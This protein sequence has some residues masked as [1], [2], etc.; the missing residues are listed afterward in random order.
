MLFAKIAHFLFFAAYL[1][2]V[3]LTLMGYREPG[4]LSA[5]TSLYLVGR[6][7]TKTLPKVYKLVDNGVAD[8]KVQSSLGP[9]L[10]GEWPA[11]ELEGNPFQFLINPF[12]FLG[13]G[14]RTD[15]SPYAMAWLDGVTPSSSW[16]A[17]APVHAYN[18]G[19][20]AG[21]PT[22]APLPQATPSRPPSS[23]VP[24]ELDPVED[25]SPAPSVPAAST[26]DAWVL[27]DPSPTHSTSVVPAHTVG[28]SMSV[29]ESVAPLSPLS[30]AEPDCP[31][32]AA[33]PTVAATVQPPA[34]QAI[35]GPLE[36]TERVDSD[37]VAWFD[38][39]RAFKHG[40]ALCLVVLSIAVQVLVTA[41]LHRHYAQRCIQG[42]RADDDPGAATYKAF[43]VPEASSDQEI[44]ELR[45]QLEGLGA[46]QHMLDDLKLS[47]EELRSHIQTAS[48]ARKAKAPVKVSKDLVRRAKRLAQLPL[49]ESEADQSLEVPPSVAS[50]SQLP[51]RSIIRTPLVSNASVSVID[52]ARLAARIL[53]ISEDI[54]HGEERMD[55]AIEE[56]V[57]VAAELPQRTP[58]R[59]TPARP[60]ASREIRGN[61]W[62]DEL[63][64]SPLA[65]KTRPRAHEVES[66]M[67]VPPRRRSRS[68]VGRPGPSVEPMMPRVQE[69]ESMLFDPVA[70]S[71]MVRGRLARPSVHDPPS[72]SFEATVSSRALTDIS[73]IF[74]VSER[75]PS[76]ASVSS[77]L[78]PPAYRARPA[79]ATES[80]LWQS[81]GEASP[82]SP[83]ARPPARLSHRR[84]EAES[85]SV[86]DE[87]RSLARLQRER[88]A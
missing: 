50:V 78:V 43:S 29:S 67:I 33:V 5:T 40:W 26:P 71:S 20:S 63:N 32:V 17:K 70:T 12:P 45:L 23:A 10:R 9:W 82:E 39:V 16:S 61:A 65:H 38:T 87:S 81:S 66:S 79:S 75:L 64:T 18:A 85:P 49:D 77:T 48:S 56:L 84:F 28:V 1:E 60:L 44:V 80:A 37:G 36:S 2:E 76:G 11:M 51:A 31:V 19:L 54:R 57:Q 46:I 25:A 59:A 88:K 15:L 30:S 7:A 62:R 4:A 47:P 83:Y 34:E 21:A 35:Y 22:T 73:T 13:T 3:L 27:T 8:F 74:A 14:A 53:K 24:E 55:R 52:S 58:A 41:C 42:E 69:P 68:E 6:T 86:V 72:R